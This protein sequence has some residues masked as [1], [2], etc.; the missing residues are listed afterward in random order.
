MD[1]IKTYK[2]TTDISYIYRKDIHKLL[3]NR[4]V[5]D[6]GCGTGEYLKYFGEG[7]L[8]L[9]ISPRN[10]AEAQKANLNVKLFDFNNPI[11]LGEQ[12]EYVFFSHVLEHLESPINFLR[13]INKSLVEDGKLIIS[14]PNENSLIH[15]FYP[16]FTGDGNHLYSFSEKNL[17]ELLTV[18]GFRV[19]LVIYDYYTS[20]T[21]KLGINAFLGAFNLFPKFISY[22]MAWAFWVVA[23]KEKEI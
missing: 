5:L 3:A 14:V 19:D 4:K 18:A 7:S 16:Y 6:L 2:F 12:F 9:D 15:L 17:K 8:G 1:Y 10:I 11:A 22:P 23:S 13:F 20:L 21:A